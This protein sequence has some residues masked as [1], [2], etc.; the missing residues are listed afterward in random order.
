MLPCVYIITLAPLS[1]VSASTV[2]DWTLFGIRTEYRV[3]RESMTHC[4]FA[5]EHLAG[6]LLSHPLTHLGHVRPP[7]CVELTMVSSSYFTCKSTSDELV[8]VESTARVMPRW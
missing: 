2:M 1:A 5:D 4:G 3:S 6:A 8:T 7:I